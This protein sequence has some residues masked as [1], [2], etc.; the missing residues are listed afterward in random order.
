[1]VDDNASN[2]PVVGCGRILFGRVCCRIADLIDR[3]ICKHD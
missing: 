3:I 2:D 1:M